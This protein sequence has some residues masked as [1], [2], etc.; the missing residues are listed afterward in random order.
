MQLKKLY[1]KD[2]KILKDFTIEFDGEKYI[3]VFIG[4][5][6]SGKSTILEA[7]A[8]IFSSVTLNEKA[9]FGFE[10]EYSVRHEKLIEETSTTSEFHTHYLSA[11]LSA[12]NEGDTIQIETFDRFGK[13]SQKINI[14]DKSKMV[15]VSGTNVYSY[16]PDNI[17]IYYSGLSEIMQ[18]LVEPHNQLISENYPY[19]YNKNKPK[20][21]YTNRYALKIF[22]N[23]K[24]YIEDGNYKIDNNLTENAIRPLAIGRKNY[25]FA[26]NHRVAQNYAMFYSFF[27]T[28][29]ANKVNPSLCLEDVLNRIPNQKVN[30]LEVLLPNNWEKQ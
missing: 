29:K 3:S 11:I 9:K 15:F 24:V 4:A 22:S 7:I 14:L 16:L 5:N 8:Q 20:G 30:N 17:A 2:Y 23:M 25:L 19:K 10:L 28:C 18:K 1:I 26:G 6:G 27:A 12:E 21:S 13:S